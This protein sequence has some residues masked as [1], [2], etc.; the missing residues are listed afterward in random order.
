M[1]VQNIIAFLLAV[2]GLVLRTNAGVNLQSR[3]L[4]DKSKARGSG[5]RYGVAARSVLPNRTFLQ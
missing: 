5:P 4:E 2:T 3:G 1:T